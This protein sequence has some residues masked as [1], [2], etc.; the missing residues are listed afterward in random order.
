MLSVSRE[1]VLADR[2]CAFVSVCVSCNNFIFLVYARS[3]N[4]RS[5][6]D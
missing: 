5:V 2:G 6:V 4:K 3:C 1:V